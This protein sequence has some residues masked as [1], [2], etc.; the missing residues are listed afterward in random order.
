LRHQ[1]ISLYEF[2]YT[3]FRKLEE[4]YSEMQFQENYFKELNQALAP[5]FIFDDQ[6]EI[7]GIRLPLNIPE[8]QKNILLSYLWK[9]QKNREYIINYYSDVEE[10]IRKIRK[11]IMDKK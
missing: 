11:H 6:Q 2:D 3:I 1:I 5:N 9:I 10:K 8:G 7:K 4:E